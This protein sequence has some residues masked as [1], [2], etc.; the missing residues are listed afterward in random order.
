MI[1]LITDQIDR[2][3]DP[4]T[5][6]INTVLLALFGT[7][8]HEGS[9]VITNISSNDPVWFCNIAPIL[10][11]IAWI[12]AGVVAFLTSVKLIREMRDKKKLK[13]IS[14]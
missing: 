4:V 11:T 10:Q 1:K 7:G 14:K 8:I 9:K 5:G 3:I 6:L 2:L 13:K 12:G